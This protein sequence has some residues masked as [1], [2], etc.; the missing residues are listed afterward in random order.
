MREE[1]FIITNNPMV[2]ENLKEY[3]QV[4]YIEERYIEVL[5]MARDYVHQKHKL[6]THPLAGSIKPNETP[7]KSIVISKNKEKLN[8]CSLS[9]IENSINM[10]KN[11]VPNTRD[12]QQEVLEDFRHIDYSLIEAALSPRL[13]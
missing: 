6:L 1:F 4:N 5:K 11:F 10:C 2:Y 9:H 3:C 7:Y 12:Y 13:I 8:F